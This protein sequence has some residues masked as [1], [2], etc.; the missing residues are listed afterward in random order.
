VPTVR[1]RTLA[2]SRRIGRAW[3]RGCCGSPCIAG[4]ASSAATG[5]ARYIAPHSRHPSPS[6]T[7]PGRC[8]RPPSAEAAVGPRGNPLG[9]AALLAG[10]RS[11]PRSTS[12]VQPRS[13]G[14]GVQV[15]RPAADNARKHR[16]RATTQSDRRRDTERW[17]PLPASSVT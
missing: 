5:T 8:A 10:S 1:V 7:P 6:S 4:S 11:G 3:S 9:R 14:P 12:R 15:F 17:R 16:E 13:R 2:G